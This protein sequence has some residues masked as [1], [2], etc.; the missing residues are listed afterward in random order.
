MV[1]RLIFGFLLLIGL[2]IGA[3]Q[4]SIFWGWQPIHN[5]DF[6]SD[7]CA[8]FYVMRG[9]EQ[10]PAKDPANN[11][12]VQKCGPD[13]V[14]WSLSQFGDLL[15]FDRP[16][17]VRLR[18]DPIDMQRYSNYPPLIAEFPYPPVALPESFRVREWGSPFAS[19]PKQ[20][21]KLLKPRWAPPWAE[22]FARWSLGRGNHEVWLG[23]AAIKD[24]KFCER[25]EHDDQRNEDFCVM[26]LVSGTTHAP[27]EVKLPLTRVMELRLE[28]LDLC[29][30]GG[31][32]RQW[33]NGLMRALFGATEYSDR[34]CSPF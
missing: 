6:A 23:G 30:F 10:D 29:R 25:V 32:V 1:R 19:D 34:G 22:L 8:L 28:M 5:A 17:R 18:I 26:T 27:L 15:R 14:H 24:P 7:D 2:V 16:A 20:A 31:Q 4:L 33:R 11:N 21:A 9:M 3:R 13:P 12:L